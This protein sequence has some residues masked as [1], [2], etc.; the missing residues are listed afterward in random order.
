MAYKNIKNVTTKDAGYG[1]Y[2]E[3]ELNFYA[4]Y[5]HNVCYQ[6]ALR[7]NGAYTSLYSSGAPTLN[8]IEL[9]G[10]FVRTNSFPEFGK[11]DA[12]EFLND[13]DRYLGYTLENYENMQKQ[14]EN[15]MKRAEEKKIQ[16]QDNLS[17]L[18][19]FFNNN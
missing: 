14:K 9:N 10:S 5:E 7:E 17:K 4:N 11:T 16:R 15:E 1:I 19:D 12:R 6:K 8:T 18:D 3:I 13:F 2:L